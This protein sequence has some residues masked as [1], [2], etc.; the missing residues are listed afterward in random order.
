MGGVIL[1]KEEEMQRRDD[2]EGEEQDRRMQNCGH[3]FTTEVVYVRD[4]GG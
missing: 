3:S 1:T 4:V 2:V